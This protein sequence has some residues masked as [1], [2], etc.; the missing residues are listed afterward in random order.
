MRK[1]LSALADGRCSGT[2]QP[3]MHAVLVVKAIEGLHC[4]FH[5]A[6]D[7]VKRRSAAAELAMWKSTQRLAFAKLVVGEKLLLKYIS[8]KI[9]SLCF[10]LGLKKA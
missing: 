2:H 9:R 1:D 6:S 5:Q 7:W 8:S 4:H 10:K 3:L